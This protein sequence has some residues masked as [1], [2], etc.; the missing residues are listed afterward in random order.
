MAVAAAGNMTRA[1]A[2][3]HISQPAVSKRLSDLEDQLGSPLFDRLARGVRLTAA[4]AVLLPHAERILA[5]SEAAQKELLELAGMRR[6]SLSVGA[7]TTIGSYLIPDLFGR[8]HRE[9]P[10]VQ[11]AL[12]IA[13]TAQIQAAVLDDRVDLGLSEGFVSSD[14]LEVEVVAHDEMVVIVAPG[15]PL[16]ARGTLQPKDLAG[17]QLLMREV[18]SGTR[19]VVEAQHRSRNVAGQHR[20]T[21]ECGGGGAWRR[22]CL[23]ADR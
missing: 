1:A 9:H 8:F 17:V 18:G 21:Q 12:E 13:N 19:D 20:S 15:H 4:G 3:L 14:A 7:S 10:S 2:Q 6:G 22:H 5:M 11:L 16:L 23:Q